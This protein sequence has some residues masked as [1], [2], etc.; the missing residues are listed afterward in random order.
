MPDECKYYAIP[1]EYAEKYHVQRYGAHG[2]SH[3]YVAQRCA[4]IMGKDPEE[5][6]IITCHLGNGSSITAVKGGKCYDTSM[7]LTPLEGLVMGTRC[8]SIDPTVVS[9]IYEQTGMPVKEITDMMTKKS[10]LL[11]ISEISGD[12]RDIVKAEAEGNHKAHVARE[13]LLRSVKRFIGAYA[14]E[15][16]HVDAM[17]FTAGIG[18]NDIE[19]REKVC[20]NLGFMGVKIDKEKN[21]CR[22]QEVEITAPGASI[23]TFIIPTNEELMIAKDTQA[24]VEAM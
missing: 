10:G 1:W 2:T 3:R 7:G 20:D 11:A 23:R 21:N 5:L 12:C 17:V 15:L 13:M 18:E 4:E 8:G 16:G 22:G 9:F 24:L 14:A 6:N 19:L